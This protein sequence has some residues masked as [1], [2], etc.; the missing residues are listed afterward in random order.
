MA[1]TDQRVVRP[2]AAYIPGSDELLV[3]RWTLTE[4]QQEKVKAF[5]QMIESEN[6]KENQ[7]SERRKT[8]NT[9]IHLPSSV[10]RDNTSEMM[11]ACAVTSVLVNGIW[12]KQNCY[13]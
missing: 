9:R 13:W 10:T 4:Q 2:P 5:R 8:A 3:P 11:H 12:T 6:L 1:T 7:V